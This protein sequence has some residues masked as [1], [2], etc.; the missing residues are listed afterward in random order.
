MNL[1]LQHKTY[2]VKIEIEHTKSSFLFGDEI[3][4]VVFCRK[5]KQHI[6]ARAIQLA[7]TLTREIVTPNQ[8]LPLI[9]QLEFI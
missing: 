8:L 9:L 1:I 5:E 7:T 6:L 4:L 3:F 2:S